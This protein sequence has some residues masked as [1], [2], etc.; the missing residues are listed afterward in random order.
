MPAA[1]GTG[2]RF[3]LDELLSRPRQVLDRT[4]RSSLPKVAAQGFDQ[5]EK[6]LGRFLAGRK[7]SELLTQVGPYHRFVAAAQAKSG[8]PKH[9]D[10]II[11]AFAYNVSMRDPGFGQAMDGL[12][13]AVALFAGVQFKL[14]LVEETVDGV[15][16]VGY[17]F[18]EDG[19]LPGDVNNIRF[20]FSPCFAAVGD[21]FFAASTIELGRELI[22]HAQAAEANAPPTDHGRAEPTVRGRRCGTAQRLRG[23]TVDAG[24]SRTGRRRSTRC[25]RRSAKFVTWLSGSG[26][27]DFDTEYQPHEFRFE[28]KWM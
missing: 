17:R 24:G 7:L 10:Q 23:P 18:P 15:T 4:A 27:L 11:P 28:I 19:A 12:L 22:Q 1:A 5:A 20:N 3:V 26:T 14:K 25:G 6:N 13:R 2:E 9:P 16:L 8:Y 21:Q